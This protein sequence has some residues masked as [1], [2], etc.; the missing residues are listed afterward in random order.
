MLVPKCQ[1]PRYVGFEW[2]VYMRRLLNCEYEHF[3]GHNTQ[4]KEL[5]V[6]TEQVQYDT[7]IN[8]F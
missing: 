5:N 1:L 7:Y 4:D 3:R 8:K 6:R 2:G